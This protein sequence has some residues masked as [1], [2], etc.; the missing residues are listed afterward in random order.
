MLVHRINRLKW[1]NRD[2]VLMSKYI[3]EKS[4]IDD[5]YDDTFHCHFSPTLP[6]CTW[7]Y[8]MTR[9]EEQYNLMARR[10]AAALYD[11]RTQTSSR[12]SVCWVKW[13]KN[14]IIQKTIMKVAD[15]M[16]LWTFLE[17]FM[18]ILN[19]IV[20][21]VIGGSCFVAW[22]QCSPLIC[23]AAKKDLPEAQARCWACQKGPL[24][25]QETQQTAVVCHVI[26]RLGQRLV[27]LCEIVEKWHV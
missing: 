13:Q 9:T 16:F 4:I 17:S 27:R 15:G 18:C 2:R 7:Y 23:L 11:Q 1:W 10:S 5:S 8:F 25:W 19:H 6:T 22:E 21:I 3:G 26:C 20:V 24:K 12:K 14:T